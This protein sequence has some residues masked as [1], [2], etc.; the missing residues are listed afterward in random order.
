MFK[1]APFFYS[2]M[3]LGNYWEKGCLLNELTDEILDLMWKL[4]HEQP[5]EVK[6]T[7][8]TSPGLSPVAPLSD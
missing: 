1:P 8:S 4:A 7:I 2:L 5:P 3:H 6:G